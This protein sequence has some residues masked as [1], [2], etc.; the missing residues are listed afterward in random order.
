MW[1]R[2]KG[3]QETRNNLSLQIPWVQVGWWKVMLEKYSGQIKKVNSLVG[4][5]EPLKYI[6]QWS[7]KNHKGFDGIMGR[8]I[9][10]MVLTKREL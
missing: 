9:I 10:A 7:G 1:E 8:K 3:I 4:N 6:G 5:T 2:D